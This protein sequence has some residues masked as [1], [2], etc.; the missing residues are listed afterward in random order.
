MAETDPD[1]Q[2]VGSEPQPESEAGQ[3]E[4]QP[5]PEQPAET[6]A[7]VDP[8]TQPD[9]QA[10]FLAS[11]KTNTRLARRVEEFQ[12]TSRE[13]TEALKI[14]RQGQEAIAQATMPP[15]QAAALIAAGKGSENVGQTK[16][17]IEQATSL[18]GAQQRVLKAALEGA[19]LDTSTIDWANDAASV[20]EW[21]ERVHTSV[22]DQIAKG[23][24][25]L[26][27]TVQKAV[28]VNTEAEKT[29]LKDETR[30]TLKDMGADKID[31]AAGSASTFAQRLATL[32]PNSKEFADLTEKALAG[33]LRGIR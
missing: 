13:L 19:G 11:Q 6:T 18:I 16:R 30:R 25:G 26:L 28:K 10:A 21:A 24:E 31:T 9:W 8:G 15:D 4:G 14:I 33:Q 32:D 12:A 29:R 2:V 5:A 7:S 22:Q 1:T 3:P 27:K 23:R 17:A 20:D